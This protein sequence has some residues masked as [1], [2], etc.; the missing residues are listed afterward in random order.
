MNRTPTAIKDYRDIDWVAFDLDSARLTERT[1]ERCRFAIAALADVEVREATFRLANFA[2]ITTEDSW[3][4]AT[5]PLTWLIAA[6]TAGVGAQSRPQRAGDR[7][8]PTRP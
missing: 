2:D 1:R 7:R 6:D 8:G 5:G 3:G 4:H